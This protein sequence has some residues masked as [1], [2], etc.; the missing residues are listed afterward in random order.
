MIQ[1][2]IEVV[3]KSQLKKVMGKVINGAIEAR[4]KR[5]LFEVRRQVVHWLVEVIPKCY[6]GERVWKSEKRAVETSMN[7]KVGDL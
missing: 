3:P 6:V 2:V 4:T 5:E 7:D 1:R